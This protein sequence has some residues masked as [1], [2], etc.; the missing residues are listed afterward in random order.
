MHKA[1]KKDP[2]ARQL[3]FIMHTNVRLAAANSIANHTIKGLVWALKV[4]KRK[5]NRRKQLNLVGEEDHGLQHFSSSWILRAKAYSN[6]KETQK[7][8]ERTR[9][10]MNEADALDKRIRKEEKRA[11]RAVQASICKKQAAKE[12]LQ[13]AL[14]S[15]LVKTSEKLKNRPAKH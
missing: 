7:E 3:S 15:K 10:N 2:T 9:I 5:W 13:K 12:K 6:E 1:Y 11:A 4:E 8:A 14:K